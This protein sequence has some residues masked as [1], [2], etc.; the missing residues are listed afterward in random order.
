METS[1][2][3]VECGIERTRKSFFKK[4]RLAAGTVQ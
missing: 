4:T 2:A 1:N 3:E